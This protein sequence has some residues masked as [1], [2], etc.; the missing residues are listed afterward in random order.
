MNSTPSPVTASSTTDTA[1]QGQLREALT[2]LQQHYFLIKL[3]GKI[4]VHDHP[5]SVEM[6]RLG[7]AQKLV[8]YNRGDAS[9]LMARTLKKTMPSIDAEKVVKA[10]FT[11]P[12]TVCYE[13]LEFNPAETTHNFLNLWVG[14]TITPRP[15]SWTHI[16]LFL[17][18]VICDGNHEH[19]LYLIAYIAHALQRPW[20]KPGITLILIGGQGIGKGTLGRI[21]RAIWQSTYLHLYKTANVTGSFNADLERA[22][23]VFLD[24]ALFAGDRASSDALK[25]LVTEDIIHINEKHQPSRQIKS[26]HRF[27]IATNAEHVKHTDRDDRRDFVL[28][29]SEARKGDLAYWSELDQEIVG[30][31][32]G[33]MVDD[34]LAMDLSAFNVRAKPNTHELVE[35]KLLSLDP[36]GRYWYEFLL[37]GAGVEGGWPD[38]IA[39][40]VISE[41]TV[42]LA[43]KRLYRNPSASEVVKAVMRMCPSATKGQKQDQLHRARGL[44]L[45]P[46][47]VARAEFSAFVGGAIEWG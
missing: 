18:E 22:F 1:Q 31:G 6:G 40:N 47:D 2:I 38:F 7:T 24:E 42:G 28:R 9:L 43:G 20:E 33:A 39:T 8:F 35:Q 41:G 17:L 5:G 14:P 26:Y 45:P 29:V 23:I 3:G 44:L 10:F 34:L 16:Q 4:W 19:Y 37:D 46:L 12:D 25:S 36:I 21:L 15:G 11:H 27:V 32:V 30:G 13:G